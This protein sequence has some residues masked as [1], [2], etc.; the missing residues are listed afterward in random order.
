MAEVIWCENCRMRLGI[1]VD[2]DI[3][4]HIHRLLVTNVNDNTVSDL[5]TLADEYMVWDEENHDRLLFLKAAEKIE[6]LEF[7]RDEHRDAARAYQTEIERLETYNALLSDEIIQLR[8]ENKAMHAANHEAMWEDTLLPIANALGVNVH[9]EHGGLRRHFQ[10][11]EAIVK[12]ILH[13]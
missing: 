6:R 9:D 7:E 11:V 3:K 5:K 10:M 4:D 13:V 1:D 8:A 2:C 12:E